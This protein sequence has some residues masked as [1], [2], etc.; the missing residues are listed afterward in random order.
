[1]FAAERPGAAH[2][3]FAVFVLPRPAA[4]VLALA[5]SRM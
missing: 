2:H 3:G 5:V 4:R 1:M